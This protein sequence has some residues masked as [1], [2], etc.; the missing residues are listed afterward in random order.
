VRIPEELARELEKMAE[1][2]GVTVEDLIARLYWRKY[3]R[4]DFR[5]TY[6]KAWK[7]LSR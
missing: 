3:V 4:G 6:S 7:Y 2:E 1:A 5:E